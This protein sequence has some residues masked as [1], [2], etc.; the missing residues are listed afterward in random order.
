[1]TR[2]VGLPNNSQES[3]SWRETLERFRELGVRHFTC[4][5]GHPTSTEPVLR[6]VEEVLKPMK[7]G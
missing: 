7:S 4:D 6:F 3:E 2:E 1:M 5:F